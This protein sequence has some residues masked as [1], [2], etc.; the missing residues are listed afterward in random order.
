MIPMKEEAWKGDKDVE[1]TEEDQE[2]MD[3]DCLVW[4]ER[5]KSSTNRWNVVGL[6]A[7]FLTLSD[8]GGFLWII[9]V[10]IS[11]Y[12]CLGEKTNP[13]GRRHDNPTWLRRSGRISEAEDRAKDSFGVAS[14]GY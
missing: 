1:W 8:L 3:R 14:K 2:Q 5:C 10:C 4:K 11:V 6:V 12:K 13:Y 9:V 7:L